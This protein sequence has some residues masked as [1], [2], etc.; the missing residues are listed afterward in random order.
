MSAG[1]TV[2]Y[3]QLRNLSANQPEKI[4]K[5]ILVVDDEEM[6]VEIVKYI[7]EDEADFHVIGVNTKEEVFEALEG[8]KIHLILLDLKMPDVDG[9]E[10]YEMIR[11]KYRVPVV[12]MTGEK[13]I[14]TVRRI[15]EL[16]I[17]DY[18]TKPLHAFIVKETVHSVVNSWGR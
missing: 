7:L 14:E 4:I 16:G 6:N 17:D 10:L 2:F 15:S 13:S 12:L 18:L 3:H 8:N 1:S 9:F 5:N 11:E